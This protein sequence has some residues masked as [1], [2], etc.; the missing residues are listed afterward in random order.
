MS[1]ESH[2]T[3]RDICLELDNLYGKQSPLNSLSNLE[4]IVRRCSGSKEDLV[5]FFQH[6]KFALETKMLACKDVTVRQLDVPRGGGSTGLVQLFLCKKNILRYFL[7]HTLVDVKATPE[8]HQ[9][10]TS[11]STHDE[12]LKKV[13]AGAINAEVSWQGTLTEAS[14]KIIGFLSI[15]FT[16]G[17]DSNLRSSL[18]STVQVE[19]I[20]THS[21][22]SLMLEEIASLIRK[23]TGVEAAEVEA[24]A[25]LNR[26]KMD[27]EMIELEDLVPAQQMR[28]D[29]EEAFRNWFKTATL[30]VDQFVKLTAFEPSAMKL[31]D[32]L[33]GT[34]LA[35]DRERVAL[36]LD[37]SRMGEASHQPHLR[38]PP[39]QQE[40]MKVACQSFISARGHADAPWLERDKHKQTRLLESKASALGFA[41]MS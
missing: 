41:H 13:G 19:D 39:F 29:R 40:M 12:W 22:F 38:V 15:V 36:Y 34:F 37:S 24:A 14:R 2:R 16:D 28:E 18:K 32:S 30:T 26:P 21:P 9:L 20:M 33:K 27:D 17:L 25:T 11:L 5:W 4:M 7:Q 8:M 10:S 35:S 6:L 3:L 31:G 23:E 1:N